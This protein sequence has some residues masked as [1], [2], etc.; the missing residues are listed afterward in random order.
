MAEPVALIVGKNAMTAGMN[1]GVVGDVEWSASGPRALSCQL[2]LD[3]VTHTHK[4]V[5]IGPGWRPS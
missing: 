1:S 3:S 4:C 2:V 5:A